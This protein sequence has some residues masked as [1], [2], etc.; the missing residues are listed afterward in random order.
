MT[1]IRNQIYHS[2]E[3]QHFVLHPTSLRLSFHLGTGTGRRFEGLE[4]FALRP[5]EDHAR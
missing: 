5:G 4:T 3:E 1:E 2:F